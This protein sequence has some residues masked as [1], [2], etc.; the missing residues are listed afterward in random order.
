MEWT[1]ISN[2]IITARFYTRYTRVSIIQAYA[3]HNEK[4]EEEDE[5]KFQRRH[6]PQKTRAALRMLKNEKAPGAVQITIKML[7]QTLTRPAKKT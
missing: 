1:S 5:L 3:P 7:Q 4:E 6:P 2:R